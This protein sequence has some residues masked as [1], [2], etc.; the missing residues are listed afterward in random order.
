MKM[1]YKI[2]E[3]PGDPSMYEDNPEV[4]VIRNPLS[5]PDLT[6]KYAAAAVQHF[7]S[8]KINTYGL[9]TFFE[10]CEYRWVNAELAYSH[11]DNGDN[12]GWG[13]HL[14]I[15]ID[16][17]KWIQKMRSKS[18]YLQAIELYPERLQKMAIVH[19]RLTILEYGV[20][21]I[22]ARGFKS[23]QIIEKVSIS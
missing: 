10:M 22:L 7:A 16:D 20:F 13:E 8:Y 2:L 12:E 5:Q 4:A 14:L 3:I 21:D 17:S 23:E 11:F 1:K 18:G 15:Q 9:L 19:Y 6:I